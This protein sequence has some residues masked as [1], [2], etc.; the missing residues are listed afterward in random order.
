MRLGKRTPHRFGGERKAGGTSTSDAAQ[1]AG[2]GRIYLQSPSGPG[3][4]PI[5]WDGTNLL[6]FA[7]YSPILLTEILGEGMP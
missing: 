1:V 2:L 5:N 6:T 3:F 4:A 7:F